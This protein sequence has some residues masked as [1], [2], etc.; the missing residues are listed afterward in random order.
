MAPFEEYES[1]DGLRLAEMVRRGEV[2]PRELLASAIAR[3]EARNPALNAVVHTM[4]GGALAQAEGP[5]PDGPFRGVPL[6]LKDLLAAVAGEPLTSAC[7]FLKDF[8]PDH[9][10]ELVQR[11]RA[12]GFVFVGKTNLP[13]LGLLGVTE[14]ELFGPTRNPWNTEH[15]PGGSSGGSAAAV[16]AGMVPIGHGGDGGGSLRIPA[17]CCGLF[18]LKPS[19]GRNPLGPDI[20]ESWSGLVQEHALTRSVRDSAALLDATCGPDA[21]APYFAPPPERPYLEEAG[22]H[23]GR[24]RVGFTAESLF[25][26]TTHADC[27]AAVED[28]ARLMAALGHDVEEVCPEFDKVALRRA[29][30]A[31]VTVGTARAIEVAA[32]VVPR[33]LRA[34]FFE[35]Q[36]WFVAEIGRSMGAC[37]YQAALDRM[38]AEARRVAAFFADHDL[39]LTPTMAYPPARIG[40]FAPTTGQRLILAA[41]RALPL[42]P[43]LDRA[44][45]QLAAES[46]EATANTM[47]FNMTGQP[48]MSVPLFWNGDGLPIGSQ[49][50]A[51]YGEE[52]L[53]FR[54]AAQLESARPWFGRRPG[55]AAA[56][57][58]E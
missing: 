15:T 44:L 32:S 36:T 11:L 52:G 39:L 5:L 55:V 49:L 57:R 23:P 19:R 20:A 16:A 30:L 12:A 31:I 17:S 2:H 45:D 7:R 27:R 34:S 28:A 53:L 29:Y 51:R 54:V 3:I 41:L 43:L 24:L 56:G 58:R 50:V 13:E 18:G 1:C 37:E 40:T 25:G 26:E 22:A 6:L 42:K 33:R 47:L 9:D 46:L 10:S 14:P 8:V 48:A 21:G 4:F 35:A 38:Q